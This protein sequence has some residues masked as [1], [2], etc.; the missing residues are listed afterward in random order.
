MNPKWQYTFT[1]CQQ[2]MR[3]PVTLQPH[4]DLVFSFIC[5]SFKFHPFWWVCRGYLILVLVCI[6]LKMNNAEYLF[7]AYGLCTSS[8]FKNEVLIKS[9]AQAIGS[10]FSYW[11]AV[12]RHSGPESFVRCTYHKTLW[13]RSVLLFHCPLVSFDQQKCLTL[14]KSNFSVFS[15][16]ASVLCLAWH[17]LWLPQGHEAFLLEASLF[18]FSYLGPWSI[19]KWFLHPARGGR[20]GPQAVFPTALQV[21]WCWGSLL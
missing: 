17:H 11:L 2:G 5:L 14:M 13:P 8:L 15:F 3:V 19:W 10:I 20:P 12:V 9:I 16:V 4:H 6:N 21:V 1:S 18:S 7:C